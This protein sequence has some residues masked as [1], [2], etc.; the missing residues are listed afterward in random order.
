MKTEDLY[1]PVIVKSERISNIMM[2][3]LFG[4]IGVSALI[5]AWIE[6]RVGLLLIGILFLYCVIASCLR[7]VWYRVTATGNTVY[8]KYNKK[9]NS[10]EFRVDE[11]K[12]IEF[13]EGYYKNQRTKKFTII[14]TSE[15]TLSLAE[16]SIGYKSMLVY[17]KDKY[18]CGLIDGNAISEID[19]WYLVEHIEKMAK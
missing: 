6:R 2:I 5:V 18:D 17:L 1:S 15:K 10:Y 9:K 11:I 13:K 14:K 3:I 16:T 7:M 8:V 19:Y 4:N 12:K